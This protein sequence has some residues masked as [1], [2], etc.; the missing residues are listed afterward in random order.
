MARYREAKCKLCRR[1][2][3]KLFLRGDKC[4]T[5]KCPQGRRP[6]P[7]GQHG[8]AR[9]K[10]SEYAIRLSEKQKMQRI[11]G[12]N[13]SQLRSYFKKA[14]Q[15]SGATGENLLQSLER[16]LDNVIYRL[17]MAPSRQAARQFVAHGHVK[18][19]G[20][21]VNVPSYLVKA[22]QVVEVFE[23][24]QANVK[25]LYP[26]LA[27]KDVP[28]WLELNADQLQGK[29][30]SLPTRDQIGTIVA[31]NLIVEFYSR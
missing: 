12:L 6:Y 30:V 2:G 4:D 28:A 3:E 23:S 29:V 16:R 19:A 22:G 31:E 8:K 21:S 14:S 17:G 15:K 20:R 5:E 25:K 11:Y 10:P 7:P 24:S 26:N 13:E 1:A 27:D 9:I 18:V